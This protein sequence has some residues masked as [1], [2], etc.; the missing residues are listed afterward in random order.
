MLQK[1]VNKA[2]DFVIRTG[3]R[4]AG[5][6]IRG[7]KGISGR[8]KAKVAAGKARVKGKVEAGKARVRGLAAAIPAAFGFRG[9]GESHRV[10]VEKTGAHR[11]MVASTATEAHVVL[12]HY[13]AEINELRET[14]P[15]EQRDKAELR[16]RAN[17]ARDQLAG[18][19]GDLRAQQALDSTWL[20]G[21]QKGFGKS[22]GKLFD[23][24]HRTRMKL[25]GKVPKYTTPAGKI[26]K[27]T[28]TCVATILVECAPGQRP[29]P[30]DRPVET[31]PSRSERL[32]ERNPRLAH[33]IKPEEALTGQV[34]GFV[35]EAAAAT[36][37]TKERLQIV[38]RSTG[39]ELASA[40]AETRLLAQVEKMVAQDP[41]WKS[42]VRA[43]EIN[44]SKSPCPGCTDALVG[45]TGVYGLLAN[46]GLQLAT[47]T[48][49]SLWKGANPTTPSSVSALASRFVIRG[50]R[51]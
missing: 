8:V 22:L 45:G 12:D 13:W 23:L 11:V 35:M 2:L 5:P 41:T 40:H 33:A 36:N 46:K 24:M 18:F 14:T 42:R 10:F 37:F 47:L 16:N 4:L 25:A 9:G 38:T 49:G 29:Y 34:G 44:I 19:Q 7:I 31:D 15:T 6:I 17:V 28:V 3:L 30:G 32:R 50:P 39:D 51:P 21:R 1:P 20:A 43:I 26:A 48:W 27:G